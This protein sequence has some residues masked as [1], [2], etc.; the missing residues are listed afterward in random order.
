MDEYGWT[1]MGM[2]EIQN[3]KRT[4]DNGQSGQDKENGFPSLTPESCLG[5]LR[6][7]SRSFAVR[8]DWEPQMNTDG[9]RKHCELGGL[10]VRQTALSS[11]GSRA[12]PILSIL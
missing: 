8:K 1:Q 7:Y 2:K 11:H 3:L 5:I 9:L 4:T 10:G 12:I 6:V